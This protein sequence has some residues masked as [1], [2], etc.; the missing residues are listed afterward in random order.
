MPEWLEW[1]L[2]RAVVREDVQPS[3]LKFP[4]P[5]CQKGRRPQILT[6]RLDCGERFPAITA[7]KRSR[8]NDMP[9]ER[10]TSPHANA[11]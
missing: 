9:F 10:Q 2:F 6:C 7:V 5:S 4:T 8:L 11:N 1:H 3:P